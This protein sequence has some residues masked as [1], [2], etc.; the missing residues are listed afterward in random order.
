MQRLV[1]DA[2][3]SDRIE[4]DS[5]GTGNWHI[6]EPA[7]ERASAE[8]RARG[9]ALTSRARQVS[10]GDFFHF[11]L[12]LAMDER[13]LADLHELAPDPALR[14]KARLLRSFDP[15]ARTQ[16]TGAVLLDLDVPDPYFGGEDGFSVV[17]DLVEAACRGLLDHVRTHL[18]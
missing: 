3:L 11:D 4:V 10:A 12:L 15:A 9:V 6:G 13:N 18:L 5:A 2:G 16:T 14:D 8:A 1:A 17:F 7:D